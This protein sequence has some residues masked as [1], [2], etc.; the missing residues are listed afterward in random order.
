MIRPPTAAK[1]RGVLRVRK[2]ASASVREAT[3]VASDSVE[4]RQAEDG[5]LSSVRSADAG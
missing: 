4:A 3:H 5:P 2:S 1:R